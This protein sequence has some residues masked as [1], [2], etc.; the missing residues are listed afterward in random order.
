VARCVTACVGD[1]CACARPAQ[2]TR[3]AIST[4]FDVDD[5]TPDVVFLCGAG[6]SWDNAKIIAEDGFGSAEYVDMQT[7]QLV[8]PR[9]PKLLI[10]VGA[11]CNEFGTTATE[12]G[13]CSTVLV[14]DDSLPPGAS[15]SYELISH[16][17]KDF[18][19]MNGQEDVP[20]IAKRAI[21]TMEERRPGGPAQYARLYTALRAVAPPQRLLCNVGSCRVRDTEGSAAIRARQ[22]PRV[23]RLRAFDGRS[24]AMWEILDVMERKCT[25]NRV[26]LYGGAGCGRTEL[27]AQMMLWYLDR[28]R[29]TCGIFANCDP[30]S[31]IAHYVHDLNSFYD[32]AGALLQLG[33]AGRQRADMRVDVLLRALKA[34]RAVVVFD[35]W[36]CLPA[37]AQTQLAALILKFPPAVRVIVTCRG[38]A[39][40]EQ[41]ARCRKLL[42]DAYALHVP[43]IESGV[44][45]RLFFEHMERSKF[46]QQ[47]AS[48]VK[49]QNPYHRGSKCDQLG[50][51]SA[52]DT[53]NLTEMCS[54]RLG[55]DGSVHAHSLLMLAASAASTPGGIYDVKARF[56]AE[57]RR[58]YSVPV[59]PRYGLPGSLADVEAEVL[60]PAMC[61]AHSV[62]SLRHRTLVAQLMQVGMPLSASELALVSGETPQA[63][64]SMCSQLVD[65]RL[66]WSTPQGILYVIP[67]VRY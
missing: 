6:T 3:D 20:T 45:E 32:L 67:A 61:V 50:D 62:L 37:Q 33:M 21:T 12:L 39:T 28:S 57:Q 16:L 27:V 4:A 29:L 47:H 5:R 26:I 22:N 9:R 17:F 49:Y 11:F 63:I 51:L 2:F 65:L 7:L 64:E 13:V 56:E 1:L 59:D 31:D 35:D 38:A 40:C 8:I 36:Q 43:G 34:S 14:L 24:F 60:W 46:G 55:L 19:R 10:A 18:V 30:Q 54:A 42:P 23:F 44:A 58:D 66:I 25:H 41:V 48:Y 53:Q 15:D 52:E